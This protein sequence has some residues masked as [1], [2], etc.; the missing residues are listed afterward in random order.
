MDE[1]YHGFEMINFDD[2]KWGKKL[3]EG[4][5]GSVYR[6]SYN[7]EEYAVKN[8][9]YEDWEKM[10]ST[11]DCQNQMLDD[12]NYELKISKKVSGLKQV[13]QV[14][15]LCIRYEDSKIKAVL[16]LMELLCSIGDLNKYL[17]NKDLWMASRKYN[18]TL[19]PKVNTKYITYNP[20]ENIYWSFNLNIDMKIKVGKMMI[21]A[22]NELHN[23]GIIHC[24]IKPENMVYHNSNNPEKG[25]L[26]LIDLGA[27]HFCNVDKMIDIDWYPGTEGYRAPE[28]DIKK[29]C[30][31]S[32]IY[33]LGVTLIELWCGEIWMNDI[34]FKVCRNEVLRNLR[35][36]EK[37]NLEFGKLLRKCVSLDY[38]KRPNGKNLLSQFKYIFNQR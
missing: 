7:N 32:D 11:K 37:D 25:I 1:L 22:V 13:I 17:Q 18:E 21:E 27:C 33:S 30:F 5:A 10:Y 26:K 14:K 38:R 28:Q 24:D 20:E 23:C 35:K 15:K 19:I 8:Y 29:V 2:I 9:R 6:C 4:A 36:I 12:I 31:K 34:G 16:V 3:G